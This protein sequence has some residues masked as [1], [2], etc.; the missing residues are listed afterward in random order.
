MIS[1]QIHE[2]TPFDKRIWNGIKS[3]ALF[4]VL[5]FAL[6][7]IPNLKKHPFTDKID[8]L[9]DTCTHY[10]AQSE[11]S[12]NKHTSTV[13][14]SIN[15]LRVQKDKIKKYHWYFLNTP[16]HDEPK[17]DSN[18]NIIH[19]WLNPPKNES[20]TKSSKKK[21]LIEGLN[22]NQSATVT[23]TNGYLEIEI[24]ENYGDKI[25]EITYEYFKSDG[26]MVQGKPKNIILSQ[27]KKI[28][29]CDEGLLG[30]VWLKSGSHQKCKMESIRQDYPCIK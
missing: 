27:Q 20:P 19:K 14:S 15:E 9:R 24:S 12:K 29:I 18:K 13:D 17:I 26:T 25:F 22:G 2:E 8:N 23:L 4:V 30:S 3:I 7:F 28:K 11:I 16:D 6:I 1:P 5:C 10:I 21:P